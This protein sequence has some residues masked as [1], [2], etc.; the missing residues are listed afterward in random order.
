MTPLLHDFIRDREL[1][2]ELSLAPQTL[3]IWR[4]RGVGPAFTKIG[5]AC[6]YK[7]A[8][9][10]AWLATRHRQPKEAA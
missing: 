5:R 3:A 9:I 7:R 6:W 1:A 2:Q 10:E 4:H 8:D